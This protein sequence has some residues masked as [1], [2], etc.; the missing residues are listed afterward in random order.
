[1][2]RC[3]ASV[4]G[5]GRGRGCDRGRRAP[6]PT[7][8]ATEHGVDLV[9]HKR[10]R[11]GAI[12]DCVAL[13]RV[14]VGAVAAVRVRRIAVRLYVSCVGAFEPSRTRREL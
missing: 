4:S 1:V 10:K 14:G 3:P 7:A 13:V 12:F 11:D 8:T 5:R 9:L 6:A 2:S